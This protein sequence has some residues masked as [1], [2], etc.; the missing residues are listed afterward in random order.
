MAQTAMTVRGQPAERGE[1]SEL[2]LD[3]MNEEIRE[4]R[5]LR[6]ERKGI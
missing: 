1:T 5:R 3:E 4:V 6:K 2:P